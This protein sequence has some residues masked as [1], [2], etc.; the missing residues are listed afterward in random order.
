MI[1]LRAVLQ[2]SGHSH[3]F[4]MPLPLPPPG[5]LH[6][7]R[8]ALQGQ[9]QLSIQ[10][11][12]IPPPSFLPSAHLSPA[13]PSAPC[14]HQAPVHVL[15][16]TKGS[17]SGFLLQKVLL[18]QGPTKSLMTYK[19]K[20]RKANTLGRARPA[21]RLASIHL[22]KCRLLTKQWSLAPTDCVTL[23]TVDSLSEPYFCTSRVEMLIL[24]LSS[25]VK[26]QERALELG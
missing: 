13:Q 7:F 5:L 10:L 15:R 3:L 20:Q 8:S 19:T 11:I 2:R 25:L 21:G 23:D 14:P 22:Q 12:P 24:P 9:V 26:T 6:L 17:R 1:W 4:R 16:V 18:E